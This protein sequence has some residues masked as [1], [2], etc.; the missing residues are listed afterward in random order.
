MLRLLPEGFSGS[1]RYFYYVMSKITPVQVRHCCF[2]K[3][4][5]KHCLHSCITKAIY[6]ARQ[7]NFA[8]D[9]DSSSLIFATNE[10]IIKS[11]VLP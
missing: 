2:K 10:Y 9:G 8:I 11:N 7:N 6:A 4:Q 1:K 3:I 5:V